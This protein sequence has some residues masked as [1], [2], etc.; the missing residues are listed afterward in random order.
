MNGSII[1]TVAVMNASQMKATIAIDQDNIVE[2]E[3]ERV[4][5]VGDDIKV[6]NSKVLKPWF[7]QGTD[8][9]DQNPITIAQLMRGAIKLG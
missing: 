3:V 2:A 5:D 6:L 9:L 7:L 8:W 4:Y 1:G